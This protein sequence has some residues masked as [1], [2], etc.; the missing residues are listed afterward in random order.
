MP[1]LGDFLGDLLTE[2]TMARVQADLESV[3]VAELYANHPLLRHMPVPRFRLPTVHLD[4]PVMI[5]GHDEGQ[6]ENGRQIEPEKIAKKF[7][8]ILDAVLEDYNLSVQEDDRETVRRMVVVKVAEYQ[9]TGPEVPG[10]L[11]GTVGDLIK[12][13]MQTLRPS[14][15]GEEERGAR[16]AD[17]EELLANIRENLRRRAMTVFIRYVASPRRLE[18]EMSTMQVKEAGSREILARVKM[19]VSEDGVEWATVTDSDGELVERLVHE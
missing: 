4:V 11:T 5:H 14:L 6:D 15:D 19:M 9:D 1:K 3:R 12:F 7:V 16:A 13:V 2:I 17:R 10:S 8:E 18:A